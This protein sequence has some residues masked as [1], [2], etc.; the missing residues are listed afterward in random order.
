MFSLNQI[1]TYTYSLYAEFKTG[2]TL[3]IQFVVSKKGSLIRSKG[4]NYY[5]P[6]YEEFLNYLRSKKLISF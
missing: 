3:K 1:S 2:E 6:E 4:I 5:F